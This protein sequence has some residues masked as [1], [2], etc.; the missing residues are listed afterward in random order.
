MKKETGDKET[1]LE[2]F[3]NIFPEMP[4]WMS[5]ENQ[6]NYVKETFNNHSPGDVRKASSEKKQKPDND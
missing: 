2:K 3:K 4:E 6:V 5:L 1:L